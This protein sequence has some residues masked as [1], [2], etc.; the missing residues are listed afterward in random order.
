[1]LTF[2]RRVLQLHDRSEYVQIAMLD[3]MADTTASATTINW[4]SALSD[5]LRKMFLLEDIDSATI[6]VALGRVEVDVCMNRWR[7]STIAVFGMA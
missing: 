4:F 3:C 7:A 1:M 5:L 2:L 6:D